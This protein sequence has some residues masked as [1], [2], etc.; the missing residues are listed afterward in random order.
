[1]FTTTM[2]PLP[3]SNVETGTA[4]PAADSIVR[5]FG[6]LDISTNGGTG[7]HDIGAALTA[8]TL[9]I[10]GNTVLTTPSTWTLSSTGSVSGGL[11]GVGALT[12]AGGGTL[13][14]SGAATTTGAT[15]VNAGTLVL[16]GGATLPSVTVNNATVRFDGSTAATLGT[17]LLNAGALAGTGAVNVTGGF[18]TA[19]SGASLTGTGTLTTEL[20]S[21]STVA[22]SGVVGSLSI[23]DGRRWVNQGTLTL[24]D[25]APGLVATLRFPPE[26]PLRP[27]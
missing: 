13:S 26:A 24:G 20:G 12:K 21:V 17:L 15:T 7:A 27:R 1:M 8:G 3:R 9:A 16:A 5:S 2:F 18:T 11:S 23:L 14:V 6:S 25:N 4:C 10:S 22:F 19:G